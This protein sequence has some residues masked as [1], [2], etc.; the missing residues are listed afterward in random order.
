MNKIVF[1]LLSRKFVLR[2]FA[3]ITI[4]QLLVAGSTACLGLAGQN[5]S[6][7]TLF[8]WLL[9]GFLVLNLLPHLFSIWLKKLELMGYFD[10]YFNFIE[11]RLLSNS[12]RADKWQNHDK[13]ERFLTALGPDAEGYLTAVAFSIFDIYLFGLTIVLNITSISL[14]VDSK[15]FYAFV[16]SGAFSFLI[17]QKYTQRIEGAVAA[18]QEAK[19]DFFSYIL[20]SWDNVLLN[21]S[22]IYRSYSQNIRQKFELT[23]ENIGKAA[24]KSEGLVFVLSIVSSLPV[25]ALLVYLAFAHSTQVAYLTGLL[26]TLPK[27]IMILG[28]FRAFFSQITNLTS[29]AARFQTSWENSILEE[30]PLQNAIKA[31]QIKVNG[32]TLHS[33]ETLQKNISQMNCGRVLITGENGSGKSTL[34]L[35]LNTV[36]PDSFYLPASP[37]L[38]MGQALGVESTGERILK[39]LD[40]IAQQETSKVLLDEWDA[41]LDAQNKIRISQRLDEL[42]QNKVI[43]EVRH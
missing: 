33:V 3:M 17:F 36:L 14:V 34:L 5:A 39:H 30:R 20:K 29:F 21:N 19:T 35:H 42:A 43:L 1:K 38:E 7:S 15:F 41:N 10:A 31:H 23:R 13:K 11:M 9:G 26:V 16:I 37:H 40:F 25:F 27:Q 2:M 8:F 6:N 22:S 32:E 4:Q 18:E 12:G 28:N 24:F